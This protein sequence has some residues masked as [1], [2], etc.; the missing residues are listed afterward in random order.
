MLNDAGNPDLMNIDRLAEL[1]IIQEKPTF[2]GENPLVC[3]CASIDPIPQTLCVGIK[4]KTYFAFDSNNVCL[5]DLD[6][7][8][9][10]AVCEAVLG[11]RRS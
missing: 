11:E 5:P 2:L 3:A 6:L 10:T 8:L 4:T 7:K 1:P 9:T